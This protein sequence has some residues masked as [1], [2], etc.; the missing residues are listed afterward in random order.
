M[1]QNSTRSLREINQRSSPTPG[2][3]RTPIIT[4]LLMGAFLPPLD[5]YIVNL[6]LP[7]IGNGLRTTGGQLQLI[8][9]CYASAYAVFLI[10][11]GRLGDLYGRKR[12]F[13]AGMAGF[14]IA[15][16]I[17]GFAP[18]GS[19]L[20]LGRILQGASAAIMAPQVLATIRT[21]FSV[22]EQPRAIG[23]YGSVFGF[24]SIVGQLFGGA[25]IT[26]H[27]LGLTWQS[28]FLINIPIGAVA[29]VGA[30]RFLPE[31]RPWSRPKIDL[32]G[33]FLLSL[34]LASIIYP[35][36]RGRE[37]GWPAWTFISFAVSLP[38]LVLFIWFEGWLA[39]VGGSPLVDLKLFKNRTF[40]AGLAMAFLF[41]CISVF[42][43]T[44]GIYLQ[45]GLGWSPLA[46]GVG[47]LPFALGFFAGTLRSAKLY[48]RIGNH[49]LSVGFGLLAGGFA[50]TAGALHAGFGPGIIFYVGLI[51]A[52]VGQGLLQPSTVRI[53]LTE[54]E[55]EQAGLAAGVVTSILQVGAAVGVAAV[56]SVFF[57]VLG[58]Q[59]GAGAYG[60]AFASALAVAAVLQMLGL[61]LA[62][63]MNHRLRRAVGAMPSAGAIRSSE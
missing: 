45:S 42:F 39:K 31:A 16:A 59:T 13:M 27:P 40:V 52:G 4:V 24:A 46:S 38:L 11:G 32:V 6:A 51:C 1:T 54:V 5:F 60:S 49:I 55:P 25:S 61:L 50:I 56:G 23:L 10:T 35:L 3:G 7:A 48:A 37:A 22:A 14:I 44:F 58:Q 17:C 47:I 57:A 18:N 12:M 19:I 43:L 15:S 8:V 33:V 34:L 36:T 2:L 62:T 63:K 26:L 30:M 20:I 29:L 53:V 9:S 28:I 21:I 41:Y